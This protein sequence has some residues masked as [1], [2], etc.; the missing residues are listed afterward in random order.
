MTDKFWIWMFE[1]GH[2]RSKQCLLCTDEDELA[3]H[4]TKQMLI[5]YMIEYLQQKPNRQKWLRLSARRGNFIEKLY[6]ELV[7]E[8]EYF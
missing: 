1:N 3:Y 7:L 5:G 4:P 2:A 8:I 6:D